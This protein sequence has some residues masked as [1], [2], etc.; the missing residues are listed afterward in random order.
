[1]LQRGHHDPVTAWVPASRPEHVFPV[2][3]PPQRVRL[4]SQ[5]R[6]R[7]VKAGETLA[8]PGQ[9]DAPS[10]LVLS[11]GVKVEVRTP[12]GQ[13]L[14]T[15]Y[16]AGQFSGEVATFTGRPQFAALSALEDGEVV[17]LPRERLRKLLQT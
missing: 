8:S 9:R 14:V 6:T 2:L 17:E 16:R 5:G 12:T 7:R 4:A 10:F 3:T 13:Q 15:V 1:M 11:G